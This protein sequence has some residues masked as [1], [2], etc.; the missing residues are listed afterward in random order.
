MKLRIDGDSV[1]LRL[2]PSEV[3]QLAEA[4][5]VDDSLHLAPGAALTYGLRAADVPA[6]GARW[7][8]TALTVLVPSD[9]IPAWAEGDGVGFDGAQEAGGGRRLAILVEK[10]FECLHKRPDEPDAFPNPRADAR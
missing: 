7:D 1:R 10:D 3:R 4:G 5:R 6:L 8:G 9:W 2:T